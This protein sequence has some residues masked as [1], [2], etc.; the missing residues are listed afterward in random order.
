MNATLSGL[1]IGA[2]TLTPAFDGGKT[3]Y[4]ANTTNATNK[5]TATPVDDTATIKI[6]VND[7]EIENETSATW[8]S[9]ANE[10]VVEVTKGDRKTTYTVAVTYTTGG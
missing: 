4:T 6:T 9:G 7:T 3:E 1:T 5:V 2:L 8:T 10:V